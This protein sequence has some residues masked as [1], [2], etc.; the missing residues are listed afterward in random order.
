MFRFAV[1]ITHNSVSITHN[2]KYMGPMKKKSIWICFLFL[3]PLLNSLIF[4][5]WV[6]ETEEGKLC[7]LW[8]KAQQA[9]WAC[10]RVQDIHMPNEGRVHLL[11][12]APSQDEGPDLP[13]TFQETCSASKRGLSSKP[14][15]LVQQVWVTSSASLWGLL[16]KER[17]QDLTTIKRPQHPQKKV[18]IINPSLA[19]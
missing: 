17:R 8:N 14:Q 11:A 9:Q 19:L 18:C 3:F 15:R 10:W 7:K 16:Y 12:W 4:E 5:W 1:S 2:S 6:I 13:I